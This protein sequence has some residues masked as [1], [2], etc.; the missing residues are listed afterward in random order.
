MSLRSGD[1]CPKCQ[2][3]RMRVIASRKVAQ[4]FQ[5]QRLECKECKYRDTGLVPEAAVWRRGD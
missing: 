4:R 3:G 2:R 1:T 5:Q